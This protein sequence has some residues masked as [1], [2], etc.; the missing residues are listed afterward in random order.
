M[1]LSEFSFF[2]RRLRDRGTNGP[3]EKPADR[4]MDGPTDGPMDRLTDG[5]TNRRTRPLI[6]IHLAAEKVER[7]K[8]SGL[9]EEGRRRRRKWTWLTR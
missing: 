3:T 7:K 2:E 5:C 6:E 4:P 1:N 9:E 8:E